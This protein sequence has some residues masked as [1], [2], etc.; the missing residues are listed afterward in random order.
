[1]RSTTL[2]LMA[3]GALISSGSGTGAPAQENKPLTAT[4]VHVTSVD[5]EQ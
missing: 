2:I 1:M 4:R 3:A 5:Y